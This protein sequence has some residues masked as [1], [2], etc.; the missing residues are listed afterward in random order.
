MRKEINIVFR[1]NF[2]DCQYW[3][4][5]V[6]RPGRWPLTAFGGNWQHIQIREMVN[7]AITNGK[8]S[9]FRS[10]SV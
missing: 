1:V 10:S 9:G 2:N 7:V 8:C 6:Q 5:R 3:C 4:D